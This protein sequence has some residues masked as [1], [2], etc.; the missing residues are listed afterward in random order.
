MQNKQHRIC[1]FPED[2]FRQQNL[3]AGIK[4]GHN[5]ARKS[6][7]SMFSVCSNRLI[8]ILTANTSPRT[9][10]DTRNSTF[11]IAHISWRAFYD[12]SLSGHEEIVSKASSAV[13]IKSINTR[14]ASCLSIHRVGHS[15][16]RRVAL[17]SGHSLS[18]DCFKASLR[19]AELEK[20]ADISQCAHAV[21]DGW[22]CARI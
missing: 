19:L 17:E 14:T 9:W 11:S 10:T 8:G 16:L 4:C 6:N 20:G 2:A 22:N 12:V 7:K 15:C 21:S 18:M 13:S 3:V 5:R 1:V